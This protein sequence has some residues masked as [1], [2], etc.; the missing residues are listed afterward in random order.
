MINYIDKEKTIFKISDLLCNDISC[1][2]C[3]FL[4]HPY[5]GGCKVEEYIINIPNADVVERTTYEQTLW[6]RDIAVSQLQEIGKNLGEKMD[7]VITI[8]YGT[9]IELEDEMCEP[10]WQCSIC[11]DWL[12]FEEGDPILNDIK[13]YPNCG[14]RMIC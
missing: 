10:E 14:A 8:K 6:E 1:Q 7:D 11:G 9:W 13:Y 5:H 4:K 12:F 2:E 3:P